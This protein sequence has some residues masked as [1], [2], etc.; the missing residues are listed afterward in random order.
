MAA[1]AWTR[2]AEPWRP[3][4]GTSW[5]WQISGRVDTSHDVAMYDVD[6]FDT[7]LATIDRLHREGRV[8]IC[9]FSAGTLETF[10][11]DVGA[12]DEAAIG[13]DLRGWKRERWLDVRAASVRGLMLARLDLAVERRCDGVE[14]DNVDAYENESGFDLTAD[15]QLAYDRF[16]AR[17]AHARGLSV[18]L[19]NA[20][21]LARALEPDFDWALD[22]ECLVYRE[23]HALAPFIAAGKAV[24]H[25]EY[26]RGPPS[27]DAVRGI[28]TSPAIRGFS[29]LVKTREIGP[30]RASCG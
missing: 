17:E 10:R 7:P 19:K 24:F 16:L 28:C 29:T 6:L 23:C 4:T 3:V 25:V 30:D 27:P 14:P 21:G 9:Y 8:V 5:E 2:A 12:L 1:H 22:E 13:R 18:G 20:V 15:D 11:H 26:T